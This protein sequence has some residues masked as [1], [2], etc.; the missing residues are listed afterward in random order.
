MEPVTAV[1]R[2]ASLQQRGAH[3]D[4]ATQHEGAWAAP[5]VGRCCASGP[6]W[7][8]PPSL[9]TACLLRVLFAQ[10]SHSIGE[11][12]QPEPVQGPLVQAT[13]FVSPS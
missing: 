13:H 10:K 6:P 12:A 4:C 7:V 5:T 3:S 9:P 1:H 2:S 11:A 8:L